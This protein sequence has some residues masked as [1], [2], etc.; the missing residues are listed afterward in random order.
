[1]SVVHL[2]TIP[3]FTVELLIFELDKH[4]L[5][6]TSLPP[7]LKNLQFFP[8]LTPSLGLS[9]GHQGLRCMGNPALLASLSTV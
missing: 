7:S 3:V 9:V 4:P 2:K 6:S 5:S 8:L 1:M